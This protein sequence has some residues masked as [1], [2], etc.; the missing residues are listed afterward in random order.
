MLFETPFSVD[1]H[2]DLASLLWKQGNKH[3]ARQLIASAETGSVLGATTDPKSLLA[4]W[5]EEATLQNKQYVFWQS[6][7]ARNP[8]Y[9]DAYIA[10]TVLS[11]SLG[12][13]DE[14]HAWLA[15]AQTIDPNSL[16]VQK[17]REYLR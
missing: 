17:L 14:A 11:F 3:E 13:T 6:V 8:D 16:T 15:K 12:K 7:A 5:E 10:L 2:I 9:R 4:Q 1:Q